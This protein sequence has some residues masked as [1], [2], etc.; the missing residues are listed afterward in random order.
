MD[1]ERQL[2]GSRHLGALRAAVGDLS[3]LLTRAYG[4]T[5]ALKLVGDRHG[6][7]AR[8]RRAVS[9]CACSDD[10]LADRDRRRLCSVADVG[11]SAVGVDG[12]NCLIT[13]QL[14]LSGGLVLRGRDRCYRD[15]AGVHG[16]FRQGRW[17]RSAIHAVGELAGHLPLCWYLD[18]PVSGSGE[19][20]GLLLQ[21]A[22][23]QGWP[24]QAELCR[25]P[26]AALTHG[27]LVAVTSDSGV[28]DRCGAWFDLLGALIPTIP[29]SWV[30][31]LGL[32]MAP[33]SADSTGDL[34]QE[35]KNE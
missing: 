29:G 13:L 24:W 23:E 20:R 30:V 4:R 33:D 31:D 12:L 10:A 7:D 35:L 15:L 1:S 6:L 19:L 11:S 16:A 21:V 32:A 8:Q 34:T 26:D 18:R 17:T 27:D 22:A 28:L 25:D 14:A 3:W 9:C 5:A 2:F